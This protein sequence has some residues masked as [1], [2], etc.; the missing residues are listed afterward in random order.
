MQQP[1]T[2]PLPPNFKRSGIEISPAVLRE[3]KQNAE[4]VLLMR[5]EFLPP[6]KKN[7]EK[8]LATGI[9]FLPPVLRT[10]KMKPRSYR[11]YF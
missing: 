2:H 3:E 9:E 4:Q 8:V 5:Q 1:L 10:K 11:T 7:R 6:L